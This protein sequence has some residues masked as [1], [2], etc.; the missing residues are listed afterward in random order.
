M[1]VQATLRGPQHFNVACRGSWALRAS[2]GSAVPLSVG[3]PILPVLPR[4]PGSTRRPGP[5]CML[6]RST[7]FMMA[8]KVIFTSMGIHFHIDGYAHAP[9]A[10]PAPASGV[11]SAAVTHTQ[12]VAWRQRQCPAPHATPVTA[13]SRPASA[14]RAI[15]TAR[16]AARPRGTAALRRCTPHFAVR[17]AGP[18]PDD[19]TA[20]DTRL[21][22]AA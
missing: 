18:P 13:A 11:A 6:F 1:G 17:A 8:G 10:T 19:L 21:T 2:S 12:T 5:G 22:T 7:Q 3:I 16:R 4:P 20:H 15:P 9:L 14:V